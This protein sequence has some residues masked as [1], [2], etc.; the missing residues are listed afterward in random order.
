MNDRRH[1][2]F[3]QGWMQFLLLYVSNLGLWGE[4]HFLP[5]SWAINFDLIF[6]WVQYSVFDWTIC[7]WKTYSEENV[8]CRIPTVLLFFLIDLFLYKSFFLLLP[9][10]TP[11]Q[12][13]FDTIW[14]ERPALFFIVTFSVFSLWKYVIEKDLFSW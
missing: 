10:L 1:F 11:I 8:T 14:P 9:L 4:K 7:F 2:N 3:L 5:K 6:L 13:L 12:F